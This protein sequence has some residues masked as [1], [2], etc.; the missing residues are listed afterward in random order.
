[1]RLGILIVLGL[2]ACGGSQLA[3]LPDT[4]SWSERMADADRHDERAAIHEQAAT[5]HELANQPFK[6]TCGDSVLF[7]QVKNSARLYGAILPCYSPDAE[8]AVHQRFLA[9][10]ERRAA[11][12]DRAS[13]AM[14]ARAEDVACRTI[15][16][17]ERDVSLFERRQE[18]AQVI[19]HR[20]GGALVGVRIVFKPLADIT[21]DSARQQIECH[22]ARWVLLGSNADAAAADPTLV[23]GSE[24]HVADRRDHVE[25]LVVTPDEES[26][27]IA[28]ARAER[29]VGTQAG[30]LTAT[31]ER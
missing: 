7:D 6:Y 3:Q 22:Q 30:A 4:R 25:V 23:P 11:R 13:A 17:E 9:D 28:V 15:P 18:I 5:E 27:A 8:A 1:M 12:S 19:P 20:E 14:L 24:T 2:A 31:R 21:A 26:A 16:L 10:R 29:A